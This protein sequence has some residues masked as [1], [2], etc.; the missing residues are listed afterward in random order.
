VKSLVTFFFALQLTFLIIPSEFGLDKPALLDFLGDAVTVSDADLLLSAFDRGAGMINALEFLVAAVL[1]SE[2]ERA[3]K[4]ATIFDCFDFSSKGEITYDELTI[5]V[6]CFVRALGIA[7]GMHGD[8]DETKIEERTAKSFAVNKIVKKADFLTYVDGAELLN[9]NTGT[10]E[11]LFYFGIVQAAE[12]TSN[13]SP[14]DLTDGS[15]AVEIKIRED[16][17]SV[18]GASVIIENAVNSSDPSVSLIR[19][20][21]ASVAIAPP[22]VA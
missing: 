12:K 16:A 15:Q 9:L 22:F 6:L 2:G 10:K 17:T 14:S 20:G 1:V 4:A 8:V 18:A 7:T 21:V 13:D 3:L 19:E 5:L 11:C